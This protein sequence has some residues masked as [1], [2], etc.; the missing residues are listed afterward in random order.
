MAV[1]GVSSNCSEVMYIPDST[2]DEQTYITHL[3][4]NFY[5]KFKI[6]PNE[7]ITFHDSDVIASEITV[8]HT[9]DA[10]IFP[11]SVDS[12]S[13]LL[14]SPKELD[15]LGAFTNG[16]VK[17]EI[18]KKV[19]SNGYYPSTPKTVT[20]QKDNKTSNTK[21]QKTKSQVKEIKKEPFEIRRPS[22]NSPKTQTVTVPT[23]KTSIT[24]SNTNNAKTTTKQSIGETF[25]DVFKREQGLVENATAGRSNSELQTPGAPTKIPV[26]PPKKSSGKQ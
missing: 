16:D 21:A 8:S 22:V 12:K 1:D 3:N 5:S 13:K 9:E 18:K 6:D 11:D 17:K 24:S 4:D 26:S 23:S 25:L 15:I 19:H 10:F 7:L 14:D 20:N 2:A